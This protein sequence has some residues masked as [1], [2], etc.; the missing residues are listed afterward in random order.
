MTDG[1]PPID[2]YDSSIDGGPPIDTYDSPSDEE[3]QYSRYPATPMP[4][5]ITP[6]L[7]DTSESSFLLKFGITVFVALVI[8]H[9][10]TVWNLQTDLNLV[11]T[12][13]KENKQQY[14]HIINMLE[15]MQQVKWQMVPSIR[16]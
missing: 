5:H 8:A 14:S 6:E 3:R 4:E 11:L 16:G 10:V 13:Q 12:Y 9:I 15:T 2:T 7:D 1:G